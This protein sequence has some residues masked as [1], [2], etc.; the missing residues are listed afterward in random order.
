MFEDLTVVGDGVC[1]LAI[2]ILTLGS[3]VSD[4]SL[5][6]GILPSY[7]EYGAE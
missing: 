1:D 7:V 5:V 6:L 4:E 3:S 2:A